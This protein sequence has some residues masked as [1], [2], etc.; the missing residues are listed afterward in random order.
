MLEPKTNANATELLHHKEN[1]K[2]ELYFFKSE[3]L[4]QA[5]LNTRKA[6]LSS[7]R[8]Y[9][10]YL[11]A[12]GIEVLPRDK[13]MLR[14]HSLAYVDF[15]LGKGNSLSTIR[16]RLW[17]MRSIH[18]HAGLPA[19]DQDASLKQAIKIRLN[20]QRTSRQLQ[21]K[22][23]CTQLLH[24]ITNS[25][26][27]DLAALRNKTIVNVAFDTL[28]RASEIALL[29]WDN[30]SNHSALIERSKTDQ[31]GA[32]RRA[33][34]STTS[35]KLLDEL[36]SHANGDSPYI[37]RPL[38]NHHSYKIDINPDIPL[39]YHAMLN[40]LRS[41]ISLSGDAEPEHYTFHSTRVGAAVAMRENGISLL[42][43][44]QAGGWKSEAMVIRYT[45]AIDVK[46]SGAQQLSARLNR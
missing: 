1:I 4:D 17:V 18:S 29:K 20:K 8:A 21:A 35:L 38:V 24:K 16:S 30:L 46:R 6:Y 15:L 43:I 37:F 40:A 9:E 2:E 33:Y 31:A 44:M 26:F 34:L 42:E 19:V 13:T 39:G 7:Y 28:G 22:P 25:P 11:E 36:N 45:E 41:S 5:P 10:K 27:N 23:L 14:A 32:G 3:V 12:H